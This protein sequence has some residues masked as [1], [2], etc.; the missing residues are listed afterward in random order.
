MQLTQEWRH[1]TWSNFD[2]EKPVVRLSLSLTANA[3]E[4]ELRSRQV[5]HFHGLTLITPG[6]TT[7]TAEPNEELTDKCMLQ[8]RRSTA[9]HAAVVLTT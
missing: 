5:L 9:K 1:V 2:D 3:S 4:G 8:S 6:R 7:A